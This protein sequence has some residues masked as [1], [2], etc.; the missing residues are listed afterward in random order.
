MEMMSLMSSTLPIDI[1]FV[2]TGILGIIA[3][4]MIWS[5]R[6]DMEFPERVAQSLGVIALLIIAL[7]LTMKYHELNPP[8]FVEGVIYN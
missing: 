2:V 1:M 8:Q 7:C 4:F 5:N 6:Y 3:I